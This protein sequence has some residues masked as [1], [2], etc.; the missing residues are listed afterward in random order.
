ME[1]K[2]EPCGTADIIFFHVLKLET[3]LFFGSDLISNLEIASR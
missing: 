2:V 1:P 3:F